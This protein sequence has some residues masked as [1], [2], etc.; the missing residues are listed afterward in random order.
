VP[1]VAGMGVVA[2]LA[3]H[4][5]GVVVHG[6]VVVVRRGL[7]GQQL[8]AALGVATRLVADHLG[9]H[10]VGV[11]DRPVARLRA[12]RVVHPGN[13]GQDLVRRAA[14]QRSSCCRSAAKPEFRSKWAHD[15]A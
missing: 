10:R 1:T 14:S 2:L 12:S 4:G 6:R 11:G 7:A 13:Q 5:L 3:V 9:V 15:L 8:H